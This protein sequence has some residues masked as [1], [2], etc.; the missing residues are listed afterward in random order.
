LSY[1]KYD[2]KVEAKFRVNVPHQSSVGLHA[3]AWV[4]SHKRWL[5]DDYKTQFSDIMA[6]N[7]KPVQVDKAVENYVDAVKSQDH[8]R[9][10]MDDPAYMRQVIEKL[11]TYESLRSKEIRVMADG[12]Q[13]N[14][15]L[16]SLQTDYADCKAEIKG[17]NEQIELKLKAFENPESQIEQARA[18]ILYLKSKIQ[19][20]DE[21]VPNKRRELEQQL[22]DLQV[23]ISDAEKFEKNRAQIEAEM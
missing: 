3:S 15:K 5:L 22:R 8:I 6:A 9:R 20:I 14:S 21:E 16:G 1:H 11:L 10:K 13:F 17:Q 18:R 19:S 23:K 12:T 4:D 2:S 7:F